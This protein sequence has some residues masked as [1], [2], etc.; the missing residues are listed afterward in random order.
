MTL[1]GAGLRD[2][3]CKHCGLLFT[4]VDWIECRTQGYCS[5]S[6]LPGAKVK[7]PARRVRALN[8]QKELVLPF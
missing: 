5:N 1:L 3:S 8:H 7:K 4:P 6:C 2:K